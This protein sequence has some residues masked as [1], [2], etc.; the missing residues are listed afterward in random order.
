MGNLFDGKG[1][2]SYKIQ[3]EL[4]H[5]L[6]SLLPDEPAAPYISVYKSS[7]MNWE[8]TTTGPDCNQMQLDLQL[9]S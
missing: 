8:K 4:Y 3:G 5:H 7:C 9:R 6:G 1:P 2:P